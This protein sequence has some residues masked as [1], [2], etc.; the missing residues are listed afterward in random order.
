MSREVKV[1]NGKI[2]VT[3]REEEYG[4]SL[5]SFCSNGYQSTGVYV[6]KEQFKMMRD[7]VT[8]PKVLAMYEDSK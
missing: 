6:S 3:V 2:S 4:D 8:N 1:T 5:W 7:L